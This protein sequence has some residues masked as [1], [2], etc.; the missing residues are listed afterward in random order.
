MARKRIG[1]A[2]VSSELSSFLSD[3]VGGLRQEG[4][5]KY[6]GQVC[7]RTTEREAKTGQASATL[8]RGPA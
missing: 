4:R 2:G 3:R 6:E 5:Q 7:H 1:K 8:R